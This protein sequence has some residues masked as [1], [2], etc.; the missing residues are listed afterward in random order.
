MND[1]ILSITSNKVTSTAVNITGMTAGQTL[2]IVKVTNAN[3]IVVTCT[4]NMTGW[5]TATM[6]TAGQTLT[7]YAVSATSI[8]ILSNY[9]T[10]I[11]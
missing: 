7:L 10:V 11:A 5:A 9:G 1:P 8:V 6:T 4:G 3:E 2:T